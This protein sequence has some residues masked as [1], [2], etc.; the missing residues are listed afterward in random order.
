MAYIR[1]RNILLLAK[2]ETT[3][4]VDA[5]PS[6]GS[7]A[8]KVIGLTPPTNNANVIEGNNTGGS[9]DNDGTVVGGMTAASQFGIKLKGTGV[10]GTAPEWGKLL[11]ACGFQET[12]TATAIPASP[13]ACASGGST[14]TA[15]LG[16]SASSSDDAYN[17]MPITFSG[18]VTGTAIIVDYD[19]ATKT[20]TLDTTMGGSIGGTTNYQIQKNVRYRPASASLPSMT[21]YFYIDG[22]LYK[23]LGARG[24]VEIVAGSGSFWQANFNFSGFFADT[25]TDVSVP[26]PTF[27]V[28]VVEPIW[29]AGKMLIQRLPAGVSSLSINSGNQI[30]NP[31]DP[32]R[33]E[34]YDSAQ[35]TERRIRGSIDPYKTLVA[36]RNIFDDFR[37][38]AERIIS[39]GCG[40]AVGNRLAL[41]VPRARFVSAGPSDQNGLVKDSVEFEPQGNDSGVYLSVY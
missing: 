3:E 38:G 5:S 11:K 8:I 37:T 28:G 6:A 2:Q 27:D 29:R 17:G 4:G 25:G 26:T 41:V 15:V 35:I 16:A 34:G 32:N 21:Q 36:T 22:L 14:T 31:D 19:G 30:I 20:A 1:T 23:M 18:A 24:N 40:S 39:A 7:D 9:L 12:V 13:E 10:A 33:Y